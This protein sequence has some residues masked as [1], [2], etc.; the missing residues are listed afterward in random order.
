MRRVVKGAQIASERY[1][2]GAPPEPPPHALEG[3]AALDG[4]EA[5][6]APEL[7]ERLTPREVQAQLDASREEALRLVEG[8][9]AQALGV[10]DEAERRARQ[11]IDEATAAL[12]SV[13]Q[14]ARGAGHEA[15]Y[16][17][18][19]EAAE[20]E[21]HGSLLSLRGLVDAARAERLAVIEAAE[22]EIVR[23]ALAVATRVVHRQIE[24]DPRVVLDVARAAIARL[25]DKE[26]MVVRVNP[27][28]LET[29]RQGREDLFP[30]DAR[31]VRFVGDLRV[32]RGG[33][34]IDTEAGSV[35]AKIENQLQEARKLL[36]LDEEEVT[37]DRQVSPG[38]VVGHAE[39]S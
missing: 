27:G 24:L 28:D 1:R 20:A 10:V 32:D 38:G 29:I 26:T 19:L 18:G 35:D 3:V 9:H 30:G 5:L 39:A 2:I 14:E 8:A 21:M 22:S 17:A 37:L 11:L 7:G 31:Q 16:A 6:A 15:G 12:D 36:R 23:L 33:V 13:R 34:V 25:A 4:R